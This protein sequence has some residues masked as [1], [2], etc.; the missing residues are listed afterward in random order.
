MALLSSVVALARD[1]TGHDWYSAAELKVAHQIIAVDFDEDDHV[2]FRTADGVVETVTRSRLSDKYRV[3]WARQDI[4]KAAWK[5][6][7]LRAFAG[8]GGALLCF[9][10]VWRSLDDR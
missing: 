3:R 5:S 6:T 1:T 9:V 2:G 4:L 10:S 7:T 8:C